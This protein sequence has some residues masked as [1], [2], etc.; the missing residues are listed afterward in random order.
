MIAA[1]PAPETNATAQPGVRHE[2]LARR[3]GAVAAA[4]LIVVGAVALRF[5]E[6]YDAPN[7]PL[8]DVVAEDLEG[9]TFSLASLAGRPT[10]IALWVP[11]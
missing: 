2:A 10:V 3:V 4:A 8:P 11:G 9:R 6:P 1:M 5:V 7:R